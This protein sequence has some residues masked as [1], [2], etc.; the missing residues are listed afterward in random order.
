MRGR[1]WRVGGRGGVSFARARAREGDPQALA[2]EVP[3]YVSLFFFS[4]T[5]IGLMTLSGVVT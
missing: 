3:R 2:M 4:E 1:C 5:G